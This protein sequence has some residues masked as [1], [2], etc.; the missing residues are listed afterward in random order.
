VLVRAFDIGALDC[1]FTPI[2]MK[3]NR[4]AV[5]LSVLCESERRTELTDLIYQE[6]TTLGIRVRAVERECL[7]REFVSVETEFGSIDVKIGKLNGQVVNVMPEYEQVRRIALEKSVAFRVVRDAA[8][9]GFN[10]AKLKS[11]STSS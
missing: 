9:S 7:E 6:T 3:K 8:L 4:P 5:M 2:H 1:W 10:V 11:K